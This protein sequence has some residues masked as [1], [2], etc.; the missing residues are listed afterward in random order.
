M[1]AARKAA[2]QSEGKLD[3]TP[4]ALRDRTIV[5]VLVYATARR[6]SI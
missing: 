1:E 3:L 5:G 4:V 2:E 6:L